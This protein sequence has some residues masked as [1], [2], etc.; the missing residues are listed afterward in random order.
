MQSS[1]RVMECDGSQ[2]GS[3]AR[4]FKN[5]AAHLLSEPKVSYEMLE[6]SLKGK[7]D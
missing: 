7:E 1:V 3:K 6:S 2:N 5:V 4:A